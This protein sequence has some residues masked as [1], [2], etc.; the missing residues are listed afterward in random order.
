MKYRWDKKYLYWGVTAILVMF[1]G[2]TFFWIFN[3]WA[4]LKA[5]FVLIVK[6]L[7]PI[8]YGFLIAYLLDKVCALLER[9]VFGPLGK[10]LFRRR[11]PS[12]LAAWR[13]GRICSILVSQALLLGFVA[14]LLVLLLPQIY[15]SVQSLISNAQLYARETM[16]WID[17]FL[18]DN[19][20][21]RDTVENLVGN[22]SDYITGMVQSHVL[23]RMETLLTNITGGVIGVVKLLL[24]LLLGVV[25]SVYLMYNK[26]T[27]KAQAKKL[28]YAA[29]RARHA[30][31]I[32]REVRFINRA[33][34]SFITGKIID[35]VIIGFICYIVLLILKM[36]YTS[37]VSLII[38][39]T[40]IIPIFGPFIGAVPS[41]LLILFESPVKCL[42]FV[43]FIVVL[44]QFDG[45]I[46]GPKILS[47]T[48]GLSGF[49]IMFA[50]LF[51]GKL[52]GFAGMLLGVPAMTVLYSGLRRI[53]ERRLV[54][55][56]LPTDTDR[57]RSVL[58]VDSD[59]GDFIYDTESGERRMPFGR[60]SARKNG[61]APPKTPGASGAEP[62]P[63]ADGKP[64]R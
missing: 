1:A 46:L 45:N 13:F 17:R 53:S 43:I 59:T 54:S 49:W 40:N 30:N 36:P 24:N 16:N 48:S 2:I 64:R 58:Y 41:A 12:S 9:A 51:F 47:G 55:R 22:V 60:R 29:F 14:G 57:Y 19:A 39:V 56:R 3:R 28:L 33:F 61:S 8:I 6:A 50:I 35:S 7:S 10:R 15:Q 20:Q 27:F 18:E 21:I 11:A 32:L 34:G 63:P 4:R 62:E 26:E 25:I 31:V 37:L 42:V 52:F 5:V 38:G 44:Q 23:P